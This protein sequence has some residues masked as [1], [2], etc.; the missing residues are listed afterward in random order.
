[1]FDLGSWLE[2]NDKLACSY[3]S[4]F[5]PPRGWKEQ[6][7]IHWARECVCGGWGSVC[8]VCECVCGRCGRT[9]SMY[10]CLFA[11]RFCKIFPLLNLQEEGLIQ[12]SNYL[13]KL[14]NYLWPN[15]VTNLVTACTPIDIIW[16]VRFDQSEGC[17]QHLSRKWWS[18]FYINTA[19]VTTYTPQASLI[20]ILSFPFSHSK[21]L[22]PRLSFQDSHP[23]ALIPILSFPGS[24]SKTL[25]PILSFQDSHSQTLIPRLSFPYSHSKTL[26][27][28]L[29]FQDSH[30]ASFLWW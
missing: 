2:W 30:V 10:M 23:Q 8:V 3:T 11:L 13:N 19:L 14:V 24:H 5:L 26:I 21:T 20:P 29:S 18:L 9:F 17:F 15:A 28:K 7:G 1:M 27:P 16:L 22:I 25:I 4:L 12:F 6:G